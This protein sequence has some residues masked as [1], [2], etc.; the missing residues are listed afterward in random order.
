LFLLD[1]DEEVKNVTLAHSLLLAS[2]YGTPEFT[3][4]TTGFAGCLDYIFY[5]HDQL[6]VAQVSSELSVSVSCCTF[7]MIT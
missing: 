4:Y 1:K 3:N 5:Q 7:V 2:A 6:D